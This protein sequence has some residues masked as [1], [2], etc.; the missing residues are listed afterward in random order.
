MSEKYYD[1]LK[2]IAFFERH[3]SYIP[4]VGDEYEKYQILQISESHYADGLD[5]KKYGIT[6]F[7]KWFDEEC[8]EIEIDLLENNKTRAVCGR[9]CTSEKSYAN[10]DNPLRSFM[11]IVLDIEDPHT[12]KKT[13]HLYHHF[14]FMNFYQMPAFKEKGYFKKAVRSQGKQEHMEEAAEE[15]LGK[16]RQASVEIIDQVIDILEPKA[17]VFTSIDAGEQYRYHK[18]KYANDKK[19]IYTSHPG[20]PWNSAQ[21]SLDGQTGKEVFEAKLKDLYK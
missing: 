18:G 5:T 15:L 17:I 12:T 16:C 20:R 21:V 8:P 4:F 7:S 6:Y 3:P 9:V 13:R 10:F 11:K 14:A 1:Q 2:K 19:V